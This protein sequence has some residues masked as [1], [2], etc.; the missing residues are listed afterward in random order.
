[1]PQLWYNDPST[2]PAATKFGNEVRK[3]LQDEDFGSG[4]KVK[5][6]VNFNRGDE[7]I[8]DTYGSKER[9]AR[10]QELKKEWDPRSLF[11]DLVPS[12]K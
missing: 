8:I 6:Y 7:S 1:M 3:M 10:L 12:L 9:V 11:G 5:A 4:G 2:E